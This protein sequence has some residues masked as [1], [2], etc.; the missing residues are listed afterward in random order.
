MKINV[1]ILAIVCHVCD[2]QLNQLT[3][4]GVKG[5]YQSE[6]CCTKTANDVIGCQRSA[7]SDPANFQ[8]YG[9]TGRQ[10]EGSHF[11]SSPMLEEVVDM[12]GRDHLDFKLQR[13]V[14]T[15]VV[16]GG[17]VSSGDFWKNI[18]I[19]TTHIY[20]TYYSDDDPEL[21][22]INRHTLVVE[23]RIEVSGRDNVTNIKTREAPILVGD[24]LYLVNEGFFSSFKITKFPGKNLSNPISHTLP[25]QAGAVGGND[26]GTFSFPN[27]VGVAHMPNCNDGNGGI[28]VLV[29]ESSFS[30][31]T[32]YDI[33]EI[34]RAFNLPGNKD[35]RGRLDCVCLD[36]GIEKHC[37]W[38]DMYKPPLSL[39]GDTVQSN[40][41]NPARS[42]SVGGL[43]ILNSTQLADVILASDVIPKSMT[44]TGSSVAVTGIVAGDIMVQEGLNSKL[45][46]LSATDTCSICNTG[47][48]VVEYYKAHWDTPDVSKVFQVDGKG[49]VSLV[50]ASLTLDMAY[51]SSMNEAMKNA[52]FFIVGLIEPTIDVVDV[53]IQI[54]TNQFSTQLS[55]G[56]MMVN[57]KTLSSI[58]NMTESNFRYPDGYKRETRTGGSKRVVDGE[59]YADHSGITIKRKYASGSKI[60]AAA[61]E[62]IYTTGGGL[63]TPCTDT[64]NYLYCPVGNGHMMGFDFY[65]ITKESRKAMNAL[66][67]AQEDAILNSDPGALEEAMS[68]SS[69]ESDTEADAALLAPIDS[70]FYTSGFIKLKKM[71]G[72]LVYGKHVVGHDFWVSTAANFDGLFTFF[73]EYTIPEVFQ[74]A[75][76]FDYWKDTDSN[77]VAV[78]DGNIYVGTKGGWL[79]VFDDA[80]GKLLKSHK[81]AMGRAAGGSAPG[82]YASTCLLPNGVI[83]NYGTTHIESFKSDKLYGTN[84]AWVSQDGQLFTSQDAHLVA[85]DTKTDSELWSKRIRAFGGEVGASL[86]CVG[87]T[88]VSLCPHTLDTKK[89]CVYDSETGKV[90]QLLHDQGSLGLN[91]G[92]GNF[93]R[94]ASVVVDDTYY[95]IDNGILREYKLA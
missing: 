55:L 87:P 46:V 72:T 25:R 27:M 88:V 14:D 16:K 23:Q 7:A 59:Y 10:T 53:T 4:G 86:D 22:K 69:S 57:N 15:G 78:Q 79:G 58:V 1:F 65:H 49:N 73:G 31:A 35:F 47:E 90:K 37:G 81:T 41:I 77:F 19:D 64:A 26:P 60:S 2:C 8:S 21:L 13:T 54:G 82:N 62:S 11:S 9:S 92:F 67:I 93:P 6:S 89:R 34:R 50:L 95:Q 32:Y 5:L 52:E 20:Y 83:I 76:A 71:D 75:L 24:D 45:K 42:N 51:T 84:K 18:A 17:G 12:F 33:L 40:M 56:D 28:G 74:D 66:A 38:S 68:L 3:C 39:G 85:W 91:P 61:Q 30:Y 63:W 29:G 43:D 44:F 70:D 48:Y 36:S 80:S 94:W